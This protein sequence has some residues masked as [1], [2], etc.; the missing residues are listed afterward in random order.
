[1][2][3]FTVATG[4]GRK[5]QKLQNYGRAP[6][7][8]P[9]SKN[10]FAAPRRLPSV[11]GRATGAAT[12]AAGAPCPVSPEGGTDQHRKGSSSRTEAHGL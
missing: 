2:A 12:G 5:S 6:S 9:G 10:S 11:A 8:T 3:L 7:A 4:R 1:M